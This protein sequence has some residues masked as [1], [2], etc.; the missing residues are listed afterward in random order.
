MRRRVQYFRYAPYFMAYLREEED[1]KIV[2][3]IKNHFSTT[4]LGSRF[5][6]QIYSSLKGKRYQEVILWIVVRVGIHSQMSV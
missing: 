6:L 2:R 1:K 3:K 5:V 4:L